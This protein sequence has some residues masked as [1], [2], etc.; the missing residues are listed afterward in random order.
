MTTLTAP[1]ETR[2]NSLSPYGLSK[3]S[4]EQYCNYFRSLGLPTSILRFANV[5]GPK[6][7]S[8][9]EAGVISIFLGNIKENRPLIVYGDGSTT[10]DYIYVQDVADLILSILDKPLPY[11]VN[12]GTGKETKLSDLISTIKKVTNSDPEINNQPLREGEV[13]RISLDIRRIQS[14]T[15]WDPKTSLE[16]GITQVWKWLSNNPS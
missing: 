6:Q 3:E 11:P 9:G 10:R 2:I 15:G 14:L 12:V 4:A 16:S 5:Y 7:D 8:E 1:E 13:E